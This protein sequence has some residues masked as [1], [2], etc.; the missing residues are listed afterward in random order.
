MLPLT[1]CRTAERPKATT[2]RADRA[3]HDADRAARDADRAARDVPQV[4]RQRVFPIAQRLELL[5]AL[6]PVPADKLRKVGS[7]LRLTVV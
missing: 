7:G 6:L 4:L 2:L 5:A 3:A 1:A